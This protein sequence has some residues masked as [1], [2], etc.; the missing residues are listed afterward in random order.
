MNFNNKIIKNE[1]KI[2]SNSNSIKIIN[3]NSVY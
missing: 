1:N 3:K 2:N